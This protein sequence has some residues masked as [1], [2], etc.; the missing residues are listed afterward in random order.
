MDPYEAYQPIGHEELISL[1]DL[2]DNARQNDEDNHGNYLGN[3]YELPEEN[4]DDLVS[5]EEPKLYAPK[6]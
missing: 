3:G 2:L 4:L 6:R 5:E 1:L